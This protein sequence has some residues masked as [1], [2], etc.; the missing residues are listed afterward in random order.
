MQEKSTII[1]SNNDLLPGRRQAIIQTNAWILLILTL[2]T[3]F[4]EIL[5]ENY[6][7]YFQKMHL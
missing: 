7:F 1:G 4:S 2:G 6:T 3:N 5:S